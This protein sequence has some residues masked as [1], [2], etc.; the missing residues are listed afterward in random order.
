MVNRYDRPAEAQFINTYVPLPFQQL[1]TLGKEANARVDK[2]IADLSGALDKWSDFRSPSEKDTKAWYDETMGK[3]KPI[4]DKLAQNIDSLKTPEGRAQINSLI[5]NVDR[6]KLATLK[7]SREGMLQRMEMNQ[8]LAAAGKFNEMWHGVDFANYDTLTSG[9]YNDVSPLAYKDVRELSDP[10]YAKLQRGYL[11]TK[12]GYDYF[13]NSKEDIEAVADAHYNDIVSTPEAQKHMQLFKQRTGATDEEAQAW[14]RQQIIDSN[15]DRTIRPTRE[16]NPYAKMAAEQAYRIQLKAA[17]NAQGSPVQF[18]TKLAATLMNRPYGPQT[19]GEGNKL[20]YNSQFDRIQKTFAPDSKYRDIYIN[21][22]DENGTQLPLN[23]NKSAYGIV[24]RLSTDIGSQANFINDAMLDKSSMVR[25]LAGTPIYSGNSVY[26]M[27]TPEQYINSKFGLSVNEANWNPNR[28]KFERD[29]IAGNIPNVGVTPTNK[30]LIENGIPGDEQFTQEYKA[31]VPVQYFIDNG[32]DFGETDPE[33]L[34]KNE[35]FNKF[36]S[37]LNGRLPSPSGDIVK[38]PNIKFGSD[39]NAA[40]REIQ[41][42]GWLSDPQYA[43]AIQYDG[44]YVE[45]PVMRQVLTNQQTRERANLEEFQYTKMGS[46]LNAAYRGDN[47]EL[48]YGQ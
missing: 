45:V 24:S 34:I 18:T 32:Y 33:K 35:D 1:Y 44:I 27:M 15:I 28:V 38:K 36:L 9:I 46:K 23:R 7:Q 47:E 12:G 43:A 4:I 10:Y 41:S 16:L 13:G 30:V 39:K 2:A 42:S 17:E 22:V 26:G 11:Y 31:Y 40:Y 21:R 37:T 29:L 19:S 6:Y 8:K 14:F 20:T 48:I 25:G 5:N 3:A